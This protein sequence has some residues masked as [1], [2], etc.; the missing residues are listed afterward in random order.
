MIDGQKEL[1]KI[2]SVDVSH[3]S[4]ERPSVWVIVKFKGSGQGFGGL[5]LN[6]EKLLE[7]FV[8][9]LMQPFNADYVEDLVGKK[10]YALRCWGHHNDSIV[11]L[12]SFDTGRRFTIDGW[13][14]KMGFKFK[15]PLE[16]RRDSLNLDIDSARRR[17]KECEKTLKTLEDN[18]IDWD[19]G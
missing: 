15:N 2:V 9:S 10:C 16:S 8:N 11:G 5:Y 13:R 12:E 6:T 1:G 7:S 14:K 4:D 3:E 18:Y 19:K 17:I